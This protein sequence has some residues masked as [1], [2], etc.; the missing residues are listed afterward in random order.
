MIFTVIWWTKKTKKTIVPLQAVPSPS[1][2]HFDLPP[3]LWPT[4]Q[5]RLTLAGCNYL[6]QVNLT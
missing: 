2:T 6:Q 3:L 4:M 5:A 1:C